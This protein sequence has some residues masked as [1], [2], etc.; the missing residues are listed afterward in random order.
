MSDFDNDGD[1]GMLSVKNCRSFVGITQEAMV[2]LCEGFGTAFCAD[3]AYSDHIPDDCPMQLPAEDE[4][5]PCV[6]CSLSCPCN[7]SS[8]YEDVQTD[9]QRYEAKRVNDKICQV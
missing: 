8:H 9:V 2:H 4:S 1:L 5:I 7:R 6:K 3:C